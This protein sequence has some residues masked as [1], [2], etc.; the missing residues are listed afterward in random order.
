MEPFPLCFSK[1]YLQQTMINF[2]R[3]IPRPIG[4]FYTEPTYA[5]DKDCAIECPLPN[6]EAMEE[7][8]IEPFRDPHLAPISSKL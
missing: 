7:E 2:E 1:L 6:D 4:R 8:A 3:S 5:D